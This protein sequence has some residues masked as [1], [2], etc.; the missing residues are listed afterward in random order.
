V[1][2]KLERALFTFP[3]ATNPPT[4]S[5]WNVGDGA[6]VDVVVGAVV[7]VGAIDRYQW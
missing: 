7:V 2:R 1:K 5:T 3:L 6:V 4:T